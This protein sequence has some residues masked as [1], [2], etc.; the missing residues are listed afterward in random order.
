MNKILIL[1]TALLLIITGT[2]SA[3][4][5]VLYPVRSADELKLMNEKELAS[6]ANGVCNDIVINIET[7]NKL[8]DLGDA[9]D[10]GEMLENSEK[11][12]QYLQRIGLVIRDRH[13]GKSPVWF[14][15]MTKASTFVECDAA[16]QAGGFLRK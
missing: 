10:A 7:A 14:K 13:K 12:E 15:K 8:L 11:G 4:N 1:I 5:T 3:Q 16:S 9:K 6:E 2:A